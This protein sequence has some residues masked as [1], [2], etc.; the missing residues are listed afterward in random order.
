VALAERQELPREL[1]PEPVLGLA[2]LKDDVVEGLLVW[3]G[4]VLAML[5]PLQPLRVLE[6]LEQA[7]LLLGLAGLRVLDV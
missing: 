5:E 2:D 1:G 6:M 7:M 4:P 3:Q